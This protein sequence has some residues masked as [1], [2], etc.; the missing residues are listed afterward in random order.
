MIVD[1]ANIPQTVNNVFYFILAISV[2][3]L[4]LITFLMV[5]FVIKYHR[6]RNQEPKDIEGNTWLEITWTVIPTILVLGMFYYGWIGYKMMKDVPKDAININVTGRMWSWLFEYENGVQSDTLYVPVEKPIR[7]NLKSQDVLHSFYIPAFR[8]K[9]DVVPGNEQGYVWFQPKE[10]GKY[11]VFCAEYCGQQHA[12]MKTKLVV[13]PESDFQAWL[14]KKGGVAPAADSVASKS[15]M[16]PPA[17][18][19]TKAVPPIKTEAPKEPPRGLALLNEKQCTACHSLDGSLLVATTL[20]GIFGKKQIVLTDGNE[21]RIT[22]DEAYFKK[23]I[24]EPNADIVKGFDPIMPETE[25]VTEAEIREM[26]EYV[27]KLE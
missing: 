16:P 2:V 19:E 5:F 4:L 17:A 6:K 25:G 11:D 20:K 9:H 18:S 13:L 22:I 8:V 27:K 3:L 1:T 15:M 14:I 26:I 21:R 24:L 10:L 23:S 7:I 12:Y